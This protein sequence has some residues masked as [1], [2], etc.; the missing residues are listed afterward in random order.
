MNFSLFDALVLLGSLGFFIYGMKVMSEGIQKA[1]GQRL[2]QILGAMTKN[3]FFGVL[4]GFFIT[5]L[6]QSSSATT[7]MT[8]SFVNAGLLTLVQSA[9]VMMGANIGTTITAWIVSYFGFKFNIVAVSL[10]IIAAGLPMM[11]LGRPKMRSWGE[12]LVGF[13]LLFMGLDALKHSVPDLKDNPEILGFLTQFADGGLL[14]SILFVFIGALVTIIVQ[15]SSAAMALTLVMCHNGWIPFPVAAAM[16]LGENIGTTITAELASLVGNVHAKRSA[17]IH[18][19]FNIIGVT[20]MV[21]LLPFALDMISWFS[22]SIMGNSSPYENSESIP[23]ALSYFHTFFNLTNVLLLIWFVPHLVKVAI[24]SVPSKGDDDEESH[25][26]FIGAGLMG[27]SELSILEAQKEVHKFGEISIRHIGMV[28]DLL[29]EKDKK[30]RKKLTKRIRKYEEISDRIEVEITEYLTKVASGRLSD[31]SSSLVRTMLSIINDLERVGDIC[32]QMSI[33]IGRKH[34]NKIWFTTEQRQ[35]L[36]ELFDLV[37][38]A[39]NKMNENLEEEYDKIDLQ[40]ALK[41]EDAINIKRDEI[42]KDHFQRL[43]N[44]EYDY[45]NGMIYNDLFSSMEKV[46]DHVINVNEA[47]AG[48][49]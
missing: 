14:T 17:R 36:L 27:T 40:D 10:P 29:T 8:V 3:R 46:G 11:L 45:Q 32:Y 7:V 13:A 42:R 22:E 39:M 6:V 49:V 41:N 4:T 38:F 30:K 15:S 47:I 2:R 33:G 5:S 19:M 26:N 43:E 35:Q 28:K 23:F 44:G 21:L 37:E 20:W 12:F 34:E 48:K 1:A 16:V 25:L 9:G 31:K 18:S 24:K